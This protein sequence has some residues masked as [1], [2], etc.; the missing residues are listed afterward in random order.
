MCVAGRRRRAAAGPAGLGRVAGHG[1]RADTGPPQSGPQRREGHA[2]RNQTNEPHPTGS[3][4]RGTASPS[5][6]NPLLVIA[7]RPDCCHAPEASQRRPRASC[8]PRIGRPDSCLPP[9]IALRVP[10]AASTSPVLSA[11][12]WLCFARAPAVG[13]SARTAASWN[14]RL[15]PRG[16]DRP[17]VLEMECSAHRRRRSG[18]SEERAE[19][20]QLLG[21]AE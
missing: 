21:G 19:A 5:G 12:R 6:F 17:A 9:I 8:T 4:A 11:T 14:D 20:K 18:R 13:S 10:S 7:A 16:A 3:I 1:A 15:A 2:H